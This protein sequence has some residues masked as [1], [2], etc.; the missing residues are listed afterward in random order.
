METKG[1]LLIFIVMVVSSISGCA[2]IQPHSPLPI[3]FKG[4]AQVPGMP[5]EARIWGDEPP[6]WAKRWQTH[7]KEELASLY[8][9]VMGQEHHYLAI[10]GGGAD[11][12]F[13]A[14]LLAGWSATGT[15][16]KF[17]VVTGVSTGA[18]TAPFAF[19]GSDYDSKL[20]EIYTTLSTSDL[21]K[22][23][24][25]FS[26]ISGDAA[27]GTE[28]IQTQIRKYID[29]EVIDAI[30][31]ENSKGRKLFIGTTNLEAGRS[32][33][34]NITQIAASGL[35]QAAELIHK[36]MLASASIPVAFPP[37]I[38]EVEANGQRYDEMHVDGGT[39]TQIFL[40]P[41]G[42]NWSTISERLE[43]LGPPNLYLIRNARLHPQMKPLDPKIIPIASSAISSLIRTQGIGDMYRLYY[44]AVRDGLNYN[45]AYIPAVFD[46]KPN[47]I[48][49]TNYMRKL[50]N[51]GYQL[52]KTGN[53]WH[54]TPPS[55]KDF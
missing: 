22:R 3:D 4:I 5:V 52:A 45:L 43:I 7:S 34:W 25:I 26:V 17:T 16:P 46:E 44:G 31:A 42:V 32:V 24:P 18:L 19:L 48:F 39:T 29:Q 14:G 6:P 54:R 37:V 23:R 28:P 21:L 11:G 1:K 55:L 49:D 47:E 51:L 2:A 8:S 13:G 35:P 15:R 33:I 12:A 10:S 30:A 38:I 50:F 27:L 36:V 40:Y 20:E 53:P 41:M 9:G